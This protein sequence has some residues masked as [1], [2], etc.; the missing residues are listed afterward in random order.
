VTDGWELE[1]VVARCRDVLGDPETWVTPP[2]YPASLGLCVLDSIWSIGVRYQSVE[3][4]VRAY[5]AATPRADT[6]SA[7][8]LR[9]AI[10][11]AGG[12]EGF[13][14]LV[15]NRQRTS[16]RAGQLKAVA[17]DQGAQA[18]IAAGIDTTAQL[19]SASV[20]ELAAAEAAWRAVAGQRS[21]ISW[22]AL[23]LLAGFQDVK[24]DRMVQ[25]FVVASTGPRSTPDASASV[26]VAAAG[27][28]HVEV[29]ALD[30]RIWQYQSGDASRPNSPATP[31]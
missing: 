11:G 18:L 1:L 24:P 15:G 13:A 7:T 22:R 20:D 2:G 26:V 12:P 23:R 30:H 29:R 6:S 27:V 21:G 28:L 8:D 19:R 16:T 5:S 4:V 9:R 25:R 10:A 3:R 17:V 14:R 31:Q